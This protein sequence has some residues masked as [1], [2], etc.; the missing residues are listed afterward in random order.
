LRAGNDIMMTTP[1]FYD[2]ALEAVRGGRLAEAE[3]D[4]PCAGCS[5]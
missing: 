2:G 3:I 5:R 4:A 1:E